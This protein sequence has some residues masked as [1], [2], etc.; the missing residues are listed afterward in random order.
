MSLHRS[1]WRAPGLLALGALLGALL[2]DS[3]LLGMLSL[4]PS[5]PSP[6]VVW[7][8]G[9]LALALLPALLVRGPPTGAM[10]A[11]AV[12]VLVV[13]AYGAGRIDWLRVLKDFGVQEEGAL[14]WTRLALSALALVL[15]W[16]VHVVDTAMRL[17]ARSLER[18]VEADQLAP[19]VTL[20]VR[21]GAGAGGLALAGV[22]GVAVLAMGGL[23]LG[24]LGVASKAA[25]V[26]PV[27]AA[28][29]L[30][31]AGVWLARS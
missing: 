10:L 1:V 2:M 27:L 15:V 13:S 19:A 23:A 21:T 4:L 14:D 16:V 18:G 30:A 17:R 8:A 25:F 3:S 5:P 7:V 28:L 20:V 6:L 31:G 24:E 12:P 11:V 26:A 29:L 9:A 22:A